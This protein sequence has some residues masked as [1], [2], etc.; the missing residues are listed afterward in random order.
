[1]RRASIPL[2]V[3]S[4]CFLGETERTLTFHLLNQAG[5]RPAEAKK[6]AEQAHA[7][8]Q[9]EAAPALNL[10]APGAF[11]IVPDGDPKVPSE[12]RLSVADPPGGPPRPGLSVLRID[13]KFSPGW[14][15]VRVAP[16][17][18][19]PRAIAGMP[20]ALD[21]WVYGDGSG[22]VVRLRF[23]DAT[24]QAFQEDGGFLTWKGWKQ[25]SFPMNAAGSH[26]HWGGANDGQIHYPIAWNTVFLI[27]NH[28]RQATEGTVYI[29]GPV[30]VY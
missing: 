15:F 13:Y 16:A 12:Q 1:M 17:T 5:Q 8:K 30:L 29:A 2:L 11:G 6:P 19:T 27:D 25:V 9:P 7:A 3:A 23:I 28:K 22:Q 10:T 24:K 26:D 18:R 14:K 4:V 20:K 21:L